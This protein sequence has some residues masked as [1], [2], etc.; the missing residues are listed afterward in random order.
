MLEIANKKD[1]IEIVGWR[2]AGKEQLERLK[3]QAERE[4]GQLLILTPDKEAAAG[5]S[6]LPSGLSDGKDTKNIDTLQEN[7]QEKSSEAPKF[8]R[9]S[10]PEPEMTPEERQYWNK[11]QADMKKWRE[12]NAIPEDAQEPGEETPKQPDEDM[13]DYVLRIAKHRIDK[14]TWKTAPRLED[15]LQK[16]ED[17]DTVEAARENLQRYPDSIQA[18]M[19][20]A[21]AEFQQIRH[22][23]S[24]QKA[25]DKATVKAVT[26]FAQEYMKLGFG[27]HLTRGDVERMFSSVKN[28]TGAKDIR[29][30][31]DNIMNILTDNYLRNLDQQVQKLSDLEQ[32]L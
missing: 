6:A 10:N 21:A 24:R 22:A 11:W 18:K 19:R 30:E 17:K 14:A 32:T 16:R 13:M 25:Y 3:K 15:Y 7:G 23:M 29:K 26:D 8:Q 27:D 12:A 5:L 1:N 9:V 2:F 4:D 28:A 31:V 20:M